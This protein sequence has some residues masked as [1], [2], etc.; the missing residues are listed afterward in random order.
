MSLPERVEICDVTLREAS[1]PT[2]EKRNTSPWR[3]LSM[4][5]ALQ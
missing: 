4:M 1:R 5:P 3:L 2:S